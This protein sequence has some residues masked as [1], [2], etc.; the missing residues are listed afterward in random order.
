MRYSL[1]VDI[2]NSAVAAA[3]ADG[4]GVETVCLGRH[5]PS[6][7]ALVHVTPDGAIL[8]GDDAERATELEPT[9]T[10]RL[11]YRRLDDPA[12]IRLGE[13][14]CEVTDLLSAV[15]RDVLGRVTTLRGGPPDHVVLTRP[16]ALGPRG[17]D[18]LAVAAARA[19]RPDAT[20]T[21]APLACGTWFAEPG[22]PGR[23]AVYDFGGA[24][25]EAAVLRGGAQGV[26]LVCPPDGVPNLGGV[27]LDELV[28]GHL[29][30]RLNGALTRWDSRT[31]EGSRAR[32]RVLAACATAKEMLSTQSVAEVTLQLPSGNRLCR[33]RREEIDALFRSPVAHTV[34]ALQRV[35][36]T[37]DVRPDVLVLTGGSARIP[38]VTALIRE[39]I[40]PD[41]RIEHAPDGAVAWGA[42]QLAT[43]RA[44]ALA[45]PPRGT[46][47]SPRPRPNP[48]AAPAQATEI[49]RTP[50][51]PPTPRPPTPRPPTPRPYSPPPLAPRPYPP[52][53][54]TP[55]TAGPPPAARQPPAADAATVGSAVTS[56]ADPDSAVDGADPSWPNPTIGRPLGV[57]LALLAVIVA[58][59][60]ILFV[61]LNRIGG[62]AAGLVAPQS[63][64]EVWWTYRGPL[65]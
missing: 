64:L 57:A 62:T 26:E 13:R 15:I 40:G 51:R 47:T 29:D 7:P 1:G 54:P 19:G 30:T 39:A 23:F 43:R 46:P 37:A 56:A 3:V 4:A 48:V 50:I 34:D 45:R 32:D 12:P 16:G 42:A 63:P 36:A 17:Q 14:T 55:P 10:A 24:A 41:V 52:P 44:G 2:G 28:R 25:F 21:T 59:G 65:S 8:T 9:W 20:M 18:R 60:V 33:L 35:L 49:M 31:R 6:L 5:T 11:L 61:V 53:P 27:E 22:P 38:L 58:I